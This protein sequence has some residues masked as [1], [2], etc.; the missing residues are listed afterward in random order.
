M[1]GFGKKT[2]PV[3]GMKIPATKAA[4]T[5]TYKGTTYHFCSAGCMSSFKKSPSKYAKS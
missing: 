4:G 5:E 1:F 2:D 3:C